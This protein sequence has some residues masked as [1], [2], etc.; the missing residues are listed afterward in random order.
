[1][2]QADKLH[3]VRSFKAATWV[4]RTAEQGQ[5]AAPPPSPT[6]ELDPWSSYARR[7]EPTLT[8]FFIYLFLLN[9]IIRFYQ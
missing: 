6:V 1:M 7:R 2:K 5:Q 3:L 4:Q 9:L 8:Y